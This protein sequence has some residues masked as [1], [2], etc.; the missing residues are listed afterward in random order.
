VNGKH[1]VRGRRQRAVRGAQRAWPIILMAYE[2]WQ[3]L[4]PEQ[5]DRYLKQLREY[6]ERGRKA[7]AKRRSA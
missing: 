7:I 6:G 3:K 2:R 5:R 1:P 4:P